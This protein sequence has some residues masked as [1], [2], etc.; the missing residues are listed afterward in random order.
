MRHSIGALLLACSLF[1]TVSSYAVAEEYEESILWQE[2]ADIASRNLLYGSGREQHQ[3]RGTMVFIDEDHAGTNPKFHLRDQDGTKWTAKMGVEA[4]PETAAAHLLWAVG[5]FTDEDYF[6]SRLGVEGLPARLQRGQNLVGNDGVIQNVRLERHLKGSKKIGNWKWKRNPFSGSRTFNGL[7]VMMVLMNSW[8]LKDEN[9]AI[10]EQEED[11]PRKVYVVSDLGA[12]FGTTGYS[13]SATMAKGNLMSYR[14][15]RFISKINSEFVDFNVPTRPALIYFFN[16][17]GL[18]HRLRL[19]WIGKHIPREDAKWMG[20][21]LSHL[22]P[23][24]IQD[25]FRSAGYSPKEVEGFSKIVQ[26]R[27]AELAKL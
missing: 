14:H 12:S 1:A 25:A 10:Y 8:D 20:D 23:Q 19:R 9:N 2:P 7:R 26:E 3:P 17:P 11:S 16:F 18:I 21:V 6:V 4:K 24:Q 13:W 27:I 15:S 5:Y 22:S